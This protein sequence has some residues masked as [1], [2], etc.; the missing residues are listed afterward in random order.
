MCDIKSKIKRAKE[1]IV[2]VDPFVDE[3]T[4]TFLEQKGESVSFLVCSNNRL[5]V[6]ERNVRRRKCFKAGFN[7]IETQLFRNAYMLVDNRFLYMLSRPLRYSDRRS[8]SY[9]QIMDIA[10]INRVRKL[11]GES[12]TK[13]RRQYRHF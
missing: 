7:F 8:F 3:T 10:E 5:M 1:S 13:V 4:I 12:R 6:K 9:I 11:V 2:L